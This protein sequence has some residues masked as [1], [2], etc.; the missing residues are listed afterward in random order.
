MSGQ[1]GQPKVTPRRGTKGSMSSTTYE[2]PYMRQ[3]TERTLGQLIYDGEQGKILGRT[4]KNWG[5]SRTLISI[6][7]IISLTLDWATSHDDVCA[8]NQHL[9]SLDCLHKIFLAL[10]LSLDVDIQG[11]DEV[12]SFNYQRIGKAI[13][14]H[15]KKWKTIINNPSIILAW[16]CNVF[17]PSSA[18]LNG[19]QRDDDLLPHALLFFISYETE[20]NN[21]YIAHQICRIALSG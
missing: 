15:P 2:F 7:I 17:T 14:M 18:E 10:E 20:R 1:S 21:F 16:L 12:G 19:L 5:K 11:W 9:V 8:P 3:K 13:P 6:I 4:P